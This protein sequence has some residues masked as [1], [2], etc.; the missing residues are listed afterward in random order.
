MHAPCEY[1]VEIDGVRI[2]K[3]EFIPAGFAAH[4]QSWAYEQPHAVTPDCIW[5]LEQ[6]YRAKY[7]PESVFFDF[8]HIS[9]P[10][11]RIN[12]GRFPMLYWREREVEPEPSIAHGLAFELAAILAQAEV[13]SKAIARVAD[14]GFHRAEEYRFGIM[15]ATSAAATI[16]KIAAFLRQ[17]MPTRLR[18]LCDL[19]AL[20]VYPG[21]IF[22]PGA[23]VAYLSGVFST[24]PHGR[25]HWSG[26]CAFASAC[27]A[28]VALV[29]VYVDLSVILRARNCLGV[30][31]PSKSLAWV[32]ASALPEGSGDHLFAPSHL[33]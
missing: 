31:A 33:I 14:M 12:G 13:S 1:T 11:M 23:P 25:S 32:F 19:K 3:A 6:A 4:L 21:K 10:W 22:P 2:H 15:N 26:G 20:T 30:P 27:A 24:F 9:F 28:C 5:Y 17:N 8:V 18:L 16:L 7:L 29:V